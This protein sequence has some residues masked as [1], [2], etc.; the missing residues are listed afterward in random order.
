MKFTTILRSGVGAAAIVF[1]TG[2][3]AQNALEGPQADAGASPVG[4]QDDVI[5]VTA[6][7]RSESAQEVPISLTAV[8]EEALAKANIRNVQDLPRVAPSFYVYRAPQAANTRL[9]IRG[10][11][12]SGNTAIEPSVAAFVDGIYIPR[13][14]PLLAA[15]ND[16]ARVEVLRGPQGTLFGRNAS[17]G[18][19]SFTTN[20]PEFVHSGSLDLSTGNYGRRRVNA[21]INTPVSDTLAFRVSGLYDDFGG[22]GFNRLDGK[23]FGENQTLS[24]RGALKWEPTDRLE[25]LVRADFQKQDGDGQPIVT[26]DADTVTPEAANRFRDALNGLVPRL[27][28]TY[29][30]TVNQYTEGVL[31][32]R[33]W[34]VSS[35]LS[36]D[37]G[38]VSL[39]LLSG[40]RDWNNDQF[41]RD[42][43]LTPADLFG[44]NTGFDSTS[45]SQEFQVISNEGLFGGR[46]DFVGGLYYF[47]EKYRI[48]SDINLG[49]NYCDIF[50]RNLRGDASADACLARPL[51]DAALRRFE[52]TTD[53]YAAYGQATYELSNSWDITAGLRYSYDEKS[54]ALESFAP[55][56]FAG[57]I[58][59]PDAADL[60]FDGGQFTY[61][62]NT[63]FR[64]APDVMLF[65]TVST[66]FKSGGFDEATGNALG[67][68]RIFRPENT[69][70]YE[71]GVR[72]QFFDRKLTANAT[73]FRMDI[74]D[75]QLR[76]YNGVFFSVRNAGSIRQQGIE[77][78]F[79]GTP[80]E[81]LEVSLAGT[82]LDS[83]YTEFTGA[84]GLPGFGGVQDLTGERLPFS[85]KMQGNIGADYLTDVGDDWKLNLAGR[86]S[87]TS[88]VDVG[89]GS[90]GNPQG[91][92]NGYALLGA[93]IA[94]ISPDDRF[95]LALSGQ[96]LTDR[97]YCTL[98]YSQ[99]LGNALGLSDPETGGAIQRCALGDPRTV[100]LSAKI[101]F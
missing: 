23:T 13:P 67:S 15:I 95:E 79:R 50:I 65:A 28:G 55:N 88:D 83:Q 9:F 90:D 8:S 18:A 2:A 74:D 66:G 27:D 72:S 97:R 3:L 17:V 35:D 44:R 63:T 100:Q 14:G 7:R 76:A 43:V 101:N 22:F 4:S 56:P 33:Q 32:D 42:I 49:R 96:N 59:V 16:V 25:W 12:T 45:T 61:R 87:F 62:L 73:L 40:Y 89:G 39:R 20:D 46:L 85:P 70:N 30:R 10:I 92:Q 68:D 19:L 98:R 41:E 84:P 57:T 69:N 36:Y 77:F 78:E 51:E 58:V 47:Y 99:T 34:G 21:I 37:A 81:G 80:V 24:F 5:V 54:A 29:S 52:Q 82:A 53:S 48:A 91:I 38:A 31:D 64:V 60:A 6:Q 11:G 75:F 93:R 94:L 1:G 71:L 86:L 26:V